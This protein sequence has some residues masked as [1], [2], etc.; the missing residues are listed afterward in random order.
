[1]TRTK[2]MQG[3][4]VFLGQ[5]E[6]GD[7]PEIYFHTNHMEIATCA[8]GMAAPVFKEQHEAR[9]HRNQQNPSRVDYGIFLIGTE[10]LIG[11][12][13][14][15]NINHHQQTAGFGICIFR[16]ECLSRGYGTEATRLMVQ[17]GMFHL[18]LYNIDLLVFAGNQRAI[19]AYEKVGFKHLGVR[20]GA[21]VLG[22]ERLDAVWM[23]LIQDDLDLSHLTRQ[24]LGT[25]P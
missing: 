22:G 1:M 19:R 10:Q 12:V 6:K 23:D 18:N 2:I 11:T 24:Y 17:Y 15:K 7:V 5:L 16:P 8:G 9:L 14:L 20:K 21:L 4:S 3:T 13:S 25:H